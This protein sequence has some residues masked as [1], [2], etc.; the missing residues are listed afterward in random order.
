MEYCCHAWAGAPSCWISYMIGY[1]GYD[2]ELLDMLQKQICRTVVSSI[3]AFL[4]SLAHRQNIATYVLSIGT[5]LVHIH[6]NWMSWFHFPFLKIGLLV[7][8]I[9]CK[10]FLSPF[11]DVTR[12][13]LSTVCFLARLDSGILCQ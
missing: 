11:L 10:V 3:A 1:V 12:M 13:S 7:I 6:L 8:L 4:H 5:T 9:D 2:M